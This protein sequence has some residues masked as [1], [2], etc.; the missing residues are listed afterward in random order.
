MNLED[1]IA[2]KAAIE[3]PAKKAP[4]AKK[5]TKK[6]IAMQQ[7]FAAEVAQRELAEQE[8]LAQV[9]AEVEAAPAKQVK[10]DYAQANVNMAK[11]VAIEKIAPADADTLAAPAATLE[12]RDEHTIE[13]AEPRKIILDGDIANTALRNQLDGAVVEIECLQESVAKLKS[14]NT[15][16]DPE[17]IEAAVTAAVRENELL[18]MATIEMLTSRITALNITNKA[19]EQKVANTVA[20]EQTDISKCCLARWDIFKNF[21]LM[22]GSIS[23]ARDESR[24]NTT[25]VAELV[26]YGY[27]TANF[28][29][30]NNKPAVRI[31]NLLK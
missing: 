3:A 1:I 16:T 5:P 8:A 26:E 13:T 23:L 18:M 14:I 10:I 4:A 28:Y 15:F 7:A 21:Y 24:L 6:E 29:T 2:G 25:E 22:S 17:V 12:I 11:N 30:Q 9:L 27:L 31:T 20:G 19:L